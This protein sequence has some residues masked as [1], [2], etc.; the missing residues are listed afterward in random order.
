[1]E[2]PGSWLPQNNVLPFP[3]CSVTALSA[4]IS[5]PTDLRVAV[6]GKKKKKGKSLCDDTFF[7]KQ[8]E[9]HVRQKVLSRLEDVCG[10]SLY[11]DVMELEAICGEA[12]G[13]R[14]VWTNEIFRRKRSSTKYQ[15]YDYGDYDA[16][17]E[18]AEEQNMIT[19]SVPV[20]LDGQDGKQMIEIVFRLV[21]KACVLKV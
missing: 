5:I 4:V 2:G 6:S 9:D 14:Q 20:T 12:L 21:G 19:N 15:P 17:S 16:S 8:V 10:D 13:E 7:L 18:T 3:D 1:M 11:C